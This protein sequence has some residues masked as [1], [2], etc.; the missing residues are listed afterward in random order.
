[1]E[2]RLAHV[3]L[4]VI[5]LAGVLGSCQQQPNQQVYGHKGEH[6]IFVAF[7]TGLPYWQEVKTGFTDAAKQL[8]IEAEF[9]G[10]SA[11]SPEEELKAFQQAVARKPSG[12]LLAASNLDIFKDPIDSAILEGIPV[13]CVDADAPAS[14]RV[15]FIGTDNFHAGQESGKRMGALLKGKGSIAVITV[16]GQFNLVERFLGVNEV[17]K[18]FPGI[19]IIQTIDDKGDPRIA[20]QAISALL[21]SKNRPDGIICLESSCGVGAAEALG[22]AGLVGQIPIVAFDKDAETLEWIERGAITATVAQKPYVMSYYGLKF[23]DDLHHSAVHEFKDWRT[24][25]GSPMPAWVDTGTAV[26]DKNNV[27]TFREALAAHQKPM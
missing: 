16:P 15:M 18:N 27:S 17:L 10:P 4:S 26:V 24:A 3:L 6:Y 13:I 22:R 19:K 1:M 5:L 12:I 7:N 20:G 9:A 11:F 23:L 25:P 14:H 8:G 2:P 21:Q